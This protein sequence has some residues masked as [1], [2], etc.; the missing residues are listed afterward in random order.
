MRDTTGVP[1][2]T[3][4][5]EPPATPGAPN[6]PNAPSTPGGTT[7]GGTTTKPVLSA[8]R[9]SPS[10][11]VAARRDGATGGTEGTTVTYRDTLAATTTFTVLAP[12]SGARSSMGSCLPRRRVRRGRSCTRYVSLGTFSHRDV[13]GFNTFVFTGRIRGRKLRQGRY[14]LQA[15]ARTNA[16]TGTALRIGF[17]IA[18]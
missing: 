17:R 7:G 13:A 4:T 18:T 2:V 10:A 8:L 9:L 11:F 12:R 14:K 16:G 1:S 5:Y 6:T 15:I 3:L